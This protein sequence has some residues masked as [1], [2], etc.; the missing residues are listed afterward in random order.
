ML[1]ETGTPHAT[2][3]RGSC[4]PRR[5]DADLEFVPIDDHGRL[6]QDSY[7]ASCG[8]SRSWWRSRHVSNGLGTINP[9]KVMIRRPTR[10][11]RSSSWTPPRRRRTS[12]STCRPSTAIS[13]S[14]ATRRSAHQASARSGRGAR[15]S[16]SMPPYQGGGEMIS[17]VALRQA[18]SSTTCPYRF[19]A[20]TPDMS[21]RRSALHAAMD[22]LDAI[23]I[24]HVR[25]TR[26]NWSTTPAILP[27]RVPTIRIHGPTLRSED[28]AGIVTFNLLKDV[29][30]ARRGHARSIRG[31]GVPRRPPLHATAPP[32][33]GRGGQCP[34]QLLHLHRPRRHRPPGRCTQQGRAPFGPRD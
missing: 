30:R 13:S 16:T 9:T 6:L 8:R 32:A 24:E 7:E 15:S 21:A 3:C 12:R 29:H 4:S 18:R 10:P 34:R 19:E 27:A 25:L 1:T 17:T 5:R 28:R 31:R 33:A 11:V 2:S 26:R 23:G 14:S 20:G 22:Y